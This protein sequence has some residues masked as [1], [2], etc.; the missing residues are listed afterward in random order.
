MHWGTF[1][2][3]TDEALDEPPRMLAERRAAAGLAP[4]DFDVMKVGETRTI[5]RGGGKP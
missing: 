5:T 2:N 1:E 4:E 3:L